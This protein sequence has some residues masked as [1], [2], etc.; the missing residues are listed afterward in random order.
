MW[1]FHK[2]LDLI[3]DFLNNIADYLEALE[4][5]PAHVI[6]SKYYDEDS[7]YHILHRGTRVKLCQWNEA[8]SDKL[9]I[10]GARDGKSKYFDLT[11]TISYIDTDRTF[12]ILEDGCKHWYDIIWIKQIIQRTE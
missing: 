3:V 6:E 11:V 12:K 10:P 4:N 7:L 2:I 8:E 1:W 5:K 9:F